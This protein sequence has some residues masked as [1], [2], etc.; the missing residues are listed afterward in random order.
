ME[1]IETNYELPKQDTGL[2]TLIH[3][4][5]L[6]KYIFPFMG[7][8]APLLIWKLKKEQESFIEDNAKSVINFQISTLIYT[9][10]LFFIGMIFFGGTIINYIQLAANDSISHDFV[11]VGLITT[12]FIGIGIFAFWSIADF[13]LTIIG[14]VKASNGSVYQYPF[15]IKILK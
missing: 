12:I 2:A 3:L 10:V 8:I 13:V 15:T 5:A 7:I 1:N 6:A 9:I 11:P 4:S 14:A